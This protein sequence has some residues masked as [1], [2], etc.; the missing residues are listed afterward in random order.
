[1]IVLRL[2]M[3]NGVMHGEYQNRYDNCQRQT[4]HIG[5]CKMQ[6]Q[7]SDS[8]VGWGFAPRNGE[9]IPDAQLNEE[10]SAVQTP[11]YSTLPD[12]DE[13]RSIGKNIRI[14]SRTNQRI[15]MMNNG[16]DFKGF[17]V[18]SECGAAISSI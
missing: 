13:M 1:M 2:I 8:Q 18:C 16:P 7:Y 3:R 10:Y 12:S 11:L 14:A 17:M 4:H 9:A 5:C 15:I 6:I